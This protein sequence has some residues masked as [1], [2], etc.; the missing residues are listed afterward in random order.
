[1]TTEQTGA[2]RNLNTRVAIEIR[3]LMGRYGVTQTTPTTYSKT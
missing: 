1:M 2:P 3:A